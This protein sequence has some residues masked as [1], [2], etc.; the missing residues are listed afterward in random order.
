M[1]AIKEHQIIFIV[2]K[3][4]VSKFSGTYLWIT[5]INTQFDNS[6]LIAF[7]I[8]NLLKEPWLSNNKSVLLQYLPGNKSG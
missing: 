1:P 7:F 5:I 4:N 8:E 6:I 2:Y 3:S